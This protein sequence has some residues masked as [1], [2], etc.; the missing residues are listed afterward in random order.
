MDN[1]LNMFMLWGFSCLYMYVP[2]IL[3]V[4]FFFLSLSVITAQQVLPQ[5][6]WYLNAQQIRR[7][8]IRRLAEKSVL[9][10]QQNVGINRLFIIVC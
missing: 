4:D 8:G 7:N 10:C 6:Q 5:C 1:F 3:I 9:T 2:R